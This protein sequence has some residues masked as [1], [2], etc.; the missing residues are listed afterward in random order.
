MPSPPQFVALAVKIVAASVALVCGPMVHS[1]APVNVFTF[2]AAIAFETMLDDECYNAWFCRHLRCS[3][4]TFR[5][6]CGMLRVHF[7]TKSYKKYSFERAVACTL[8]H[9]GSSGSFRETTQAFG[10]SK[11]WCIAISFVCGQR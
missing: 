3:Q 9:F 7:P 6:L 5:K 10:V 4:A 1:N 8:F 11:S 2:Q